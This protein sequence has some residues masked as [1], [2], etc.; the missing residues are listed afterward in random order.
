MFVKSFVVYNNFF[1][2]R[3]VIQAGGCGIVASLVHVPDEQMNFTR[4]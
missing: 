3:N 1:V 4:A 2:A